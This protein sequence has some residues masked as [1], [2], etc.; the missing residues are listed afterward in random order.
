VPLSKK[1]NPNCSCNS[2]WIRVSVKWCTCYYIQKERTDSWRKTQTRVFTFLLYLGMKLNT[3]FLLASV[4]T[5]FRK[6]VWNSEWLFHTV[7]PTIANRVSAQVPSIWRA[8]LWPT[9]PVLIRGKLADATVSHSGDS[10]AV[11]RCDVPPGLAL[12]AWEL[13]LTSPQNSFAI[14]ATSG[15][16]SKGHLQAFPPA[17]RTDQREIANTYWKSFSDLLLAAQQPGPRTTTNV[18]S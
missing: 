12:L 1:H 5:T 10:S 16:V 17:M 2:L 3:S 8:S 11:G 15:R 9:P 18:A 6:T 7:Q 14:G 4:Q 13:F